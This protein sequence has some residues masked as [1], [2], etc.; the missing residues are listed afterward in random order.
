VKKLK[1]KLNNRLRFHVMDWRA[2]IRRPALINITFVGVTG[3][4]GKTTTTRLV[5]AVLSHIGSCQYCTN[6]PWR[7]HQRLRVRE[8]I[9]SVDTATRYYVYETASIGPGSIASQLEILRPH[10]GVVTTVGTDHLRAFRTLEATA[11]EKGTLVERLPADGAAILNIDDPH[12]RAMIAR[13]QARVV[14]FGLSPEADIR[15]SAVA[16]CWPSRLTLTISYGKERMHIATQLIGEHWATSVLAAVA[17]GITCGLDLEAC[18]KALAGVEPVFARYSAH[19]G[20]GGPAYVLDSVKAPYWTIAAGFR[21]VATAFA[22]RKTVV[23]GTI[24]DYSGK[25]GR[26]YRKVAREALAVADRV[27]FVGP[28]SGHVAQLCQSEA[29]DR[30]FAFQTAYEASDFLAQRRLPDELIYIKGSRAADHLE[31]IML[32]QLDEVVCWREGCRKVCN[33][34]TC[35][36]YR[37]PTAPPLGVLGARETD[38][39]QAL[40]LS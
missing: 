28:H 20:A 5:Q 18:A 39:A 9:L 15:G 29:R 22:P 30:L 36:H 32:S 25:A 1:K 4:C 17:C 38:K 19:G 40:Q 24:S 27:V 37:E 33:C 23:F 6:E 34:H 11:K 7:V 3:S 2:R 12:I 8:A 26:C 16:A 10:I 14:T 21:F 13:T 31:R 35:N